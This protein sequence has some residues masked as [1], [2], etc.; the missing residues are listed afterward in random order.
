M[1]SKNN[2]KPQTT[3]KKRKNIRLKKLS[4][5]S[6]YSAVKKHNDYDNK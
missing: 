6:A 4:A 3:Q 2:Y 5:P 1:S